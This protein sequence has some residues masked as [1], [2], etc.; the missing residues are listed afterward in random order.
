MPLCYYD[1]ENLQCL[2]SV[3][4]L[5]AKV[6]SEAG[7][8]QDSFSTLQAGPPSSMEFSDR[9][10]LDVAAQELN[11][12]KTRHKSEMFYADE[13]TFVAPVMVFNGIS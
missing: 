5:P 3:S 10:S 7:E 2:S 11:E 12:F 1:S 8:L 6:D 13:D 9:H 4:T